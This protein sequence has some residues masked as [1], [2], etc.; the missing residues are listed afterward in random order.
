[1]EIYS[2]ESSLVGAFYERLVRSVKRSLKKSVGRSNLT[3]DQL[4]TLLVEIEGII[5]AQL[6]RTITLYHDMPLS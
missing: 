5:N 2:R 1:M 4:S 3:S 6:D